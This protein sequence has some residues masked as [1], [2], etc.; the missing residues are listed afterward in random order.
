MTEK[1]NISGGYEK[2]ENIT[3]LLKKLDSKEF[4]KAL[5]DVLSNKDSFKNHSTNKR[6]IESGPLRECKTV[7]L[8]ND[9]ENVDFALNKFKNVID[10]LYYL[11]N[12]INSNRELTRAYITILAPGKK[13]YPHSDTLAP[14]FS[15]I[16]RYQFYFSGNSD[17]IQSIDETLFP[18]GPGL[19]YYFDHRQK[20]HYENNSSED[21]ILMVFD[22]KK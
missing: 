13:I 6:Y 5:N 20:H 4:T 9:D 12:N 18:V 10:F 16:D 7:H 22:L 21:L 2:I 15:S 1:W 8:I 19:F 14:Y 11:K 3:T 17:M